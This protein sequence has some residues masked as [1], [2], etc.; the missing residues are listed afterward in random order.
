M[1][2]TTMISRVGQNIR[3]ARKKRGLTMEDMAKRMFVSRKT[4]Q[5]VETGE[6]TVGLGVIASALLV[7]GLEKDLEKLAEPTADTVGN[8]I[9]KEKFAQKK[10]VRKKMSVDMDF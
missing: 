8:L 10:R 3:L 2:L 9:D 1:S 7:L 4:L 5:R 6:S